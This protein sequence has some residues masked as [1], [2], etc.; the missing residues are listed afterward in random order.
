M[1]PLC[2][3][4]WVSLIPP[5][6][7]LRGGRRGHA[8]TVLFPAPGS[9]LAQGALGIDRRYGLQLG[10]TFGASLGPAREK[11]LEIGGVGDAV[12]D[13]GR[14]VPGPAR[15]DGAAEQLPAQR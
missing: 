6:H 13:E 14:A 4:P 8:P 5:G 9:A 2:S 11:D 15:V 10:Q 1:L 7:A 3:V 12:A